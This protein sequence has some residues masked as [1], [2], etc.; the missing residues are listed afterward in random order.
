MNTEKPTFVCPPAQCTYCGA[1]TAVCTRGAIALTDRLRGSEAR[2]DSAKCV[3]CGA[4][5]REC[6]VLHTPQKSEPIAIYQ[7]WCTA[8]QL[9]LQ[10][11]SGGVAS[12][13]AAAFIQTGGVVCSCRFQSGECTFAFAETTEELAAFA[14]SKYVKSRA[15]GL[16]HP[17]RQRLTDGRSVLLIA[18]PCQVA[19]AKNFIGPALGKR[20]YTVDLICHGTPMPT[21]L[22]QYLN[23]HGIDPATLA[24]L[25]FRQKGTAPLAGYKALSPTG[26]DGYTTAFLNTISQS[27]GCLDCPFATVQRVA[28]LTLGD[29]WQSDLPETE[30]RRGVSLL[31]CQSEKG[32]LLMES[33]SLHTAP[34]AERLPAEN[35]HLHTPPTP[36]AGRD[37][38]F[39]ALEAGKNPDKTVF[40]L[41]PKARAKTLLKNALHTLGAYKGGALQYG[42][43]YKEK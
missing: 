6:P 14:G 21:V 38:F 30:R 1:C 8:E 18:L 32:R 42:L 12:A 22:A 28:D 35:Q 13:I 34:A 23:S 36:G 27:D 2:I 19:A 26:N 29:A 7:G 41:Y 9:R 40:S 5:T 16:Y 24:D 11:A 25:R 17:L 3:S 20:L 15:A 10:G 43:Y 33:A 39:A 31:L 4:C 37:A